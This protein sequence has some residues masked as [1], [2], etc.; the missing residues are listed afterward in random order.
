[1][2]APSTYYEWS[3]LLERFGLGDDSVTFD[4][5]RGTFTFD[6]G[7]VYRFYNNVQDAYTERKK[8]W[9]DKFNR[10]FQIQKFRTEN[11][12]SMILQDAKFY[13]QPIV[14]FIRIDAF[15]KD[16]RDVLKKDFDEFVNDIRKNIKDSIMRN[17]PHNEKM[18]LIVNSFKFF[19]SEVQ[20]DSSNNSN[21]ASNSVETIN[22]RKIIF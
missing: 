15:P 11:D 14:K 22:K 1:M 7:T 12:I 17:H 18:I 6:S 2:T 16:L 10:L 21:G 8:R 20:I 3:L 4:L 13:L 9:I 5:Q 19:E